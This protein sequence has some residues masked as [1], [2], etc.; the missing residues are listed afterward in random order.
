ML[1]GTPSSTVHTGTESGLTVDDYERVFKVIE[2]CDQVRSIDDFRETLLGS[3][4]KRFGYQTT[5]FFRG[6]SFS[7][8]WIDP[9]PLQTGKAVRMLKAYQ[10]GWYR[11]DVFATPQAQTSFA[12]SRVASVSEFRHLPAGAQLFLSD[13]LFPSSLRSAAALLLDVSTDETALVGI[14]ADENPISRREVT[15]LRVLARP[16]NAMTRALQ[17]TPR[18]EVQQVLLGLTPRQ[19]QIAQLVAEGLSNTT[20]ALQ[21]S[22]SEDTVK[23]YVSAVL[24]HVKCESRTQLAL[25]VRG[26]PFTR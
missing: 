8:L 3:L 17:T 21:L 26:V 20:I 18:S 23:K 2:D 4:A 10:D 15:A 16:L 13:Y 11:H 7:T 22:L 24:A 12:K 5:T 9:S 6:S 14:F 19:R 25:F 1:I